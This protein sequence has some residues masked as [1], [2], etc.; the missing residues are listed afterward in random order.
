MADQAAKRIKVMTKQ[1][2]AG[3]TV[4]LAAVETGGQSI[5]V[6]IAELRPEAN[7]PWQIITR[8]TIVTTPDSKACVT[9]IREWLEK[10]SPV[11]GLGVAAF[12]P[13]DAIPTSP[14]YGYIT[15][16]PKPGWN[17]CPLLPSIMPAFTRPVPVRFD[18]DVNAAALNELHHSPFR[19][20]GMT[21]CAYIT[22]GTGVGVGVV[23]DGQ[24]V[25]G[26]L[27]PELGHGYAPRAP[28]DTFPGTCR[29][30][31]DPP[32]IEGMV[33]SGALAA[34]FGVPQGELSRVPDDDPQWMFV[35]NYLAHVCVSLVLSVSPNMI[36]FGGGVLNRAPL[37]PAIR[38]RTLE[39]LAGYINA[40]NPDNIDKYIVKSSF[41]GNAGINGATELARQAW[42]SSGSEE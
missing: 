15:T 8:T 7:P 12:G 38:K 40:L 28:G 41:G 14:T 42:L 17:N 19:T 25:H 10:Q 39:L 37:L 29:R 16:T 33:A 26:L 5:R 35:A 11:D 18:T 20:P 36:V 24:T 22:V 30:H 4:R 9:A 3:T 32:C 34:R 13:I 27:H 21:S 6:A 2:A 1:I 31:R 23:V